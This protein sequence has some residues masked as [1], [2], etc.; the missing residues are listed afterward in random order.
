MK[1]KCKEKEEATRIGLDEGLPTF[2]KEKRTLEEMKEGQI[3]TIKKYGIDRG[4]LTIWEEK[5]VKKKQKKMPK[6][7]EYV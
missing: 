1:K 5:R 7:I 3:E 2:V 4:K 6:G